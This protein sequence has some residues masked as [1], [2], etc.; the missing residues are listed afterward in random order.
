MHTCATAGSMSSVDRM[1]VA[2]SARSSRLR[3]A[4]ASRVA[5]HTPSFSLRIRVCTL[6]RKFSTCSRQ[7]QH[8]SHQ[9]Q[10]PTRMLSHHTTSQ[11]P[12]NSEHLL[13]CG[14]SS[15]MRDS[16]KREPTS[17]DRLQAA[18]ADIHACTPWKCCSTA[19]HRIVLAR[20]K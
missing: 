9:C 18:G 4:S 16:C 17:K 19:D 8:R 10:A 13:P 6:P 2:L 12:P 3:P 11:M 20:S 1:A 7:K 5:A 15:F 14:T